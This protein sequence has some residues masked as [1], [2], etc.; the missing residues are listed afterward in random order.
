M[1]RK[2]ERGQATRDRLVA[3]A[4]RLFAELGYEETSIEQV[5]HESGVSRG[6]LYHHFGGK[7]ALFEAV[8]EEVEQ[9]ISRRLQADMAEAGDL[10]ALIR[11]GCL[12]WIRM[13]GDPVI[14]QVLLVDAPSVLG[15]QRWRE[16]DEQHT[17]GEIR[18][19]LAAVAEEGRLDPAQVD[20]MAYVWI[21][22][23]NEIA[24]YIAR[25]EDGEAARREGEAV[26]DTF[27]QRLLG[28]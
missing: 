6:A 18:A 27:L 3:V 24:L 17:L 13:T 20:L 16:L 9:D 14:Q 28:A 12:G 25:A 19:F 23:M 10:F 11:A 22:V 5:L 1:N 26:V 2:A 8:L 15:W 7:E 21:A 4:T